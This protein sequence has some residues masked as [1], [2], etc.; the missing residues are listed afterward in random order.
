[1]FYHLS[2][3]LDFIRIKRSQS[4]AA[5]LI[6]HQQ[7]EQFMKLTATEQYVTLLEAFWNNVD[8]NELQ[9]EKW[10][11]CGVCLSAS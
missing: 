5:A 6:Q 2:L 7:I 8:W 1:L 3:A 11:N 10:N 4:A 9:G